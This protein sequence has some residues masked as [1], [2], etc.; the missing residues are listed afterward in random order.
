M[1]ETPSRHLV[2]ARIRPC[3]FR[4]RP[5]PHPIRERR[6]RRRSSRRCRR[7]QQAPAL[8]EHVPHPST[9]DTMDHPLRYRPP[10]KLCVHPTPSLR[11]FDLVGSCLGARLHSYRSGQI[12]HLVAGNYAI[13]YTEGSRKPSDFQKCNITFVNC[14]LMPLCDTITC[15]VDAIPICIFT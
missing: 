10:T 9:H 14:I 2:D 3:P 4:P 15:I 11:S 7:P 12:P 5:Y 13:A 6:R 1:R 8:P